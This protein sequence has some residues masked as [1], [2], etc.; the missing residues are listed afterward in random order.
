MSVNP[1]IETSDQYADT[2]AG[3]HQRWNVEISAAE[4]EAEKKWKK[5]GRRI[6][7]IYLDERKAGDDL[8]CS[9]AS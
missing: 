2:P 6:T 4:K 8:N 7:K 3:W 9:S 1:P 5:N